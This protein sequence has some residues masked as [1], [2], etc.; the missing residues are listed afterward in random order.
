MVKGGRSSAL[1]AGDD[2]VHWGTRSFGM[3]L[4]HGAWREDAAWGR[5]AP[6][7]SVSVVGARDS[8]PVGVG[9][10]VAVFVA[11]YMHEATL[12]ARNALTEL[13]VRAGFLSLLGAVGQKQRNALGAARLARLCLHRGLALFFAALGGEGFVGVPRD[14]AVFCAFIQGPFASVEACVQFFR[15]FATQAVSE[16]K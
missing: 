7:R 11:T 1:R 10:T 5:F 15:I 9:S 2:L 8:F 12:R 16:F 4:P 3:A 13:Q 6:T 14:G